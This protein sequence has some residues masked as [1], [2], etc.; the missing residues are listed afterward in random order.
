[1]R[2]ILRTIPAPPSTLLQ[3]PLSARQRISK[4]VGIAL[5]A[6]A[7]IFGCFTRIF[8]VFQYVTFDIGPDPDQIRDAFTVMKIWQGE[9]PLLGPKAY[10]FGLADFHLLPLYYYLLL[11]FTLLGQSPA[12]QAFPNALFS[13]LSIPLFIFLIYRLLEGIH[14]AKRLLISGLSGLW[15]SLLFGDIFIS[16]FQWNPS[17][18]PF[19]F[20]LLTLFYDIQSRHLQNLKVQTLSWIGCC[21]TVAILVSLHASALFI[22]P[23][24]YGIISLQFMFKSFRRS[25]FSGRLALPGLGFLAAV[26]VLTPYWI[27]EWR[28]SF[29]NTK[30][31]LRAVF[32]FSG[33]EASNASDSSLFSRLGYLVMHVF[34]LVR[35]AYF[36]DGSLPYFVLAVLAIAII[37]PLA[38]STFRGNRHIWLLWL[39]TWGLFLL[40]AAT[41]DPKTTSFYYKL[42]ILPAPI[43]LVAVVLAYGNWVGKRAIA[44]YLVIMALITLSSINNLYWDMQLMS[45]KYGPNRLINTRE[46]TQIMEQL[47]DKAEICD[48]RVERKRLEE[49]QYNYIDT[50]LI[51][52]QIEVLDACH[53]GNFVIHPKRVPGIVGS[54]LNTTDYQATYFI[55][56]RSAPVL[57]LWPIF[58]TLENGDIARSASLVKETPTAYIYRL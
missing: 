31:I 45:A 9:F 19:F 32:S 53:R 40:A 5:I 29:G 28:I 2:T 52:K 8:A 43:V 23:V 22:M 17:S 42:L 46:M 34:N 48:P 39:S 26:V 11:P 21:I 50:Y 18:I 25:G 3:Q 14:S 38:F 6:L 20:L 27:G 56:H 54:F 12:Y 49:N 55:E 51:Q 44:S 58:T 13:F 47:P 30:A 35:Q 36:W 10:G 1:M 41:L 37:I 57:N 4:Q 15:Y 7:I 16:N 24:V 33:S